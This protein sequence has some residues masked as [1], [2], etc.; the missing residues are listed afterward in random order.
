MLVLKA[1]K[2][3]SSDI[4]SSGFKY[5]CDHCH[6]SFVCEEKLSEHQQQ[7][8]INYDSLKNWET[9]KNYVCSECKHTFKRKDLLTRHIYS[10]HLRVRPYKCDLCKRAFLAEC[11]LRRHKLLTHKKN[12]LQWC[13]ICDVSFK[14]EAELVRHRDES[15]KRSTEFNCEIC[16]ESFSSEGGLALHKKYGKHHQER[17]LACDVCQKTFS[18]AFKLKQHRNRA[19]KVLRKV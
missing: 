6:R 14:D 2:S 19:H 3:E 18:F 11:D 1:E 15:H 9:W 7:Y 8:N 17:L 5:N 4:P 16:N 13:T 12:N 10:V